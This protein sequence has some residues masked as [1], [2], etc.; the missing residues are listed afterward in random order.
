MTAHQFETHRSPSHIAG[1]NIIQN[2]GY[3]MKVLDG[4]SDKGICMDIEYKE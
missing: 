4:E 3:G 2:S 1:E